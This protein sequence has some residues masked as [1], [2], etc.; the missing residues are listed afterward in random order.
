MRF[1]LQFT[2]GEP[3]LSYPIRGGVVDL[4]ASAMELRF[5]PG[6]VICIELPPEPNAWEWLTEVFAEAASASRVWAEEIRRAELDVH[7]AA[8]IG[9]G[10]DDEDAIGG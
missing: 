9:G 3:T 4:F 5:E 2:G 6:C 7:R 8:A 10:P 1:R